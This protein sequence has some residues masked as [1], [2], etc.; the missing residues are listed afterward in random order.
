MIARENL[1]CLLAEQ[2]QQ[3]C[4]MHATLLGGDGATVATDLVRLDLASA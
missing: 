4:N 1:L 2:V 3:S